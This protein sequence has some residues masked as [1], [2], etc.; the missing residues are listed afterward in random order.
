MAQVRKG[1]VNLSHGQMHYRVSGNGPPVVLLH[2]SPRSSTMYVKLLES[3]GEQFTAIA[4][5]SPGYG[6]SAPL[7]ET[8]RPEIA[9][10]ARALADTLT[11]LGIERCPVYGFHTSSKINLQFAID[12]PKRV[13]LAIMDGLNLPP[14][15]PNDAFIE[16][17]MK[18]FVMSEDGSHFAAAWSRARDFFRFFP[19]FDHS[20][21]A[22]LPLDF[23]DETFLHGYTLDML[24]AGRHYSGAYSAAMRYFAPP[25]VLKLQAPAVFM[26]R[27]N[28]PLYPFLDALPKPLPPGSSIE[29][30]TADPIAWQK[31]VSLLLEQ[32]LGDRNSRLPAPFSSPSAIPTRDYLTLSHG[33]VALQRFGN[34]KGRPILLLPDVPGSAARLT[35]LANALAVERTVYVLEWPGIGESPALSTPN[36]DAYAA[37]L[38]EVLRSIARGAVDVYAEFQAAAF[39]I[40]AAKR[41]PELVGALVLDGVPVLTATERAALSSSYCPP[42]LPQRDGGHFASLWH[43]MRDLELCWPWYDRSRLAIRNRS[44]DLNGELLHSQVLAMAK[45]LPS[46]GEA[47]NAALTCD[48][49]NALDELPK[50]CW[51]MLSATDVRDAAALARFAGASTRKQLPRASSPQE[52]GA[53]I[54]AAVASERA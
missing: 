10:Y 12:H 15:G 14:G 23:P 40:A 35:P 5:D 26:C 2:D 45:Q 32:H 20:P 53:Q 11:A 25:Q 28:D 44:P 30:L 6:N 42:I 13:S 51:L 36:V 38:I 39:A 19:W 1:F 24:M 18:P 34:A 17:Y 4:L 41:V 22:R 8:P 9:D 27:E 33:Q 46:Y 7:P 52:K 21:A 3:L 31:R 54:M 50:S 29:R 48:V 16:R 49:A 47:A 43:M 37:V